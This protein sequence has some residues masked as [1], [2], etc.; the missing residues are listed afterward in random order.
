MGEMDGG[1]GADKRHVE[2]G[3]DTGISCTGCCESNGSN[4]IG[5]I[6]RTEGCESGVTGSDSGV[7][8]SGS[9]ES[10]RTGSGDGIV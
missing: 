7:G 4:L 1:I 2:R 6:G 3:R 5:G 8:R 9:L 10:S